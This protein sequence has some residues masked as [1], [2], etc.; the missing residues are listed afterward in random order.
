MNSSEYKN[1]DE[2]RISRDAALWVVRR[3]DGFTPQEQ[4]EFLQWHAESPRHAHWYAVHFRMYKQLDNLALWKPEHSDYPN[5]ALLETNTPFFRGRWF[6]GIAASFIISLGLFFAFLV[7]NPENIDH[8]AA[9]YK[10]ETF[11]DLSLPDGTFVELNQGAVLNVKFTETQRLVELLSSEA[12]FEVA[13]N[14]ARPFVVT[15]RDVEMRAIGT[16]FNV[17]ISENKVELLVTEGN[18]MM[19]KANKQPVLTTPD[20]FQSVDPVLSPQS[21]SKEVTAGQISIMVL[22]NGEDLAQK[23]ETVGVEEIKDI[24]SWKPDS[25]SFYKTPLAQVV[26]EFNRRNPTKI[27]IQDPELENIQIV[28][29]FYSANIEKFIAMLEFTMGIKAEFVSSNRIILKK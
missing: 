4:D 13:K 5:K 25:L 29:E 14:P 7:S 15:A 17:K 1:S 24:L 9:V 20:T 27:A 6:W 16:A 11:R 10:A 22:D 28:A 19:G 18:V 23:I 3:A 2:E 12:H 21:M 8:H 26:W